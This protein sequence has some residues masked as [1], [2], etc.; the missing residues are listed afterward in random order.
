M[1]SITLRRTSRHSLSTRAQAVELG[2]F[3][4]IGQRVL[5][6][7]AE[8]CLI[9]CDRAVDVGTRLV[10]SFEVPTTGLW[11]DA[12]SEIVRIVAGRRPGDRGYCAGV[13][14]L[15]FARRD[16]LALGI[17]L[18]DYPRVTAARSPKRRVRAMCAAS[19][20]ISA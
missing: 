18:R 19:L 7:S 2:G 13:R 14:F 11:F 17:D 16:Q 1:D 12:E 5:D 9:A 15:D 3:S 10:V 8:G 6:A 4:L 20:P